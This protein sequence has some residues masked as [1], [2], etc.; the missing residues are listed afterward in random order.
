[1]RMLYLLAIGCV[2]VGLA[3][4]DPAICRQDRDERCYPV[5]RVDVEFFGNG[6]GAGVVRTLGDQ[7]FVHHHDI[8][9][10]APGEAAD[11]ITR[12]ARGAS[13]VPGTLRQFMVVE[14][15]RCAEVDA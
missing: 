7:G 15:R 12:Y 10:F 3:E 13:R 2:G 11:Y 14:F 5:G 4:P 9:G 1:M 6:T 8:E